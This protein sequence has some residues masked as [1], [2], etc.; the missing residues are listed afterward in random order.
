VPKAKVSD[1]GQ[2]LIHE[3]SSEA[4]T[5]FF[6]MQSL[7]LPDGNDLISLKLGLV[8]L[9]HDIGLGYRVSIAEI[10]RLATA[11]SNPENQF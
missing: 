7:D 2:P 6:S 11:L 4:T 10:K 9:S 8:F 1:G 3:P 5:S